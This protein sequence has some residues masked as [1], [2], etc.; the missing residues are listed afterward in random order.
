MFNKIDSPNLSIL[1]PSLFQFMECHKR[2]SRLFSGN[3]LAIFLKN[4][5]QNISER[6]H[7]LAQNLV[8]SYIIII[9]IF[10]VTT[11]SNENIAG[12]VAENSRNNF[13]DLQSKKNCKKDRPKN[14]FFHYTLSC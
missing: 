1:F 14:Y 10:L 6:M 9:C 2:L 8:R 7:P 11:D 3:L 13:V 4:L 12:R 5:V